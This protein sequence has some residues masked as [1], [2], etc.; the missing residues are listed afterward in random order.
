[1]A[2]IPPEG[3]LEKFGD[4]PDVPHLSDI[5]DYEHAVSLLFDGEAENIT[6]DRA[7]GGELFIAYGALHS[8]K[9]YFIKV[10]REDNPYSKNMYYSYEWSLRDNLDNYSWLQN[11]GAELVVPDKGATF[12]LDNYKHYITSYEYIP[13]KTLIQ[14]LWD[15]VVASCYFLAKGKKKKLLDGFKRY[16][17]VMALLHFY[18]NE[19]ETDSQKLLARPVRLMLSD[20]NGNNEIYDAKDD[21]IYLI[22]LSEEKR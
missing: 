3:F 2:G 12:L 8:G 17:Q 22:D 10:I 19:A 15:Y 4:L 16:G 5:R 14:M 21:R 1:M 18:P 20:R 11:V 9:K 7:L 13:G 6:E